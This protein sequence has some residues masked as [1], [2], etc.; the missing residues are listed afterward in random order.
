LAAII[1]LAGMG[2]AAFAATATGHGNRGVRIAQSAHRAT[3]PNARRQG[4]P[5]NATWTDPTGDD[6]NDAPDIHGI[7]AAN[8]CSGNIQITVQFANRFSDLK[9]NDGVALVMDTDQN[10]STGSYG[11]DYQFDA[12]KDHNG[13]FVWSKGSNSFVSANANNAQ[14]SYGAGGEVFSMNRSD[15]GYPTVIRFFI[16][17]TRDFGATWGDQAPDG[18]NVYVYN[19]AVPGRGCSGQTTTTTPT[20]TQPQLVFYISSV[21]LPYSGTRFLVRLSMVQG[22]RR[23]QPSSFGCTG[24]ILTTPLAT[25]RQNGPYPYRTCG[26]NIPSGTTGKNVW[27]TMTGSYGGRQMVPRT[28][29]FRIH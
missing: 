17:T 11:F 2:A 22:S 15:I 23:F 14:T 28:V 5:G 16:E 8:D 18:N 29:R 25:T 19:L 1:A 6:I 12:I 26:I 24:R 9:D 13:L 10:Y 3:V 27:V 4:V 21:G 7:T 20:T